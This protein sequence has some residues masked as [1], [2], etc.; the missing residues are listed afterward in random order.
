M[1]T[2]KNESYQSQFQCC[3]SEMKARLK[4]AMQN[5]FQSGQ[6]ITHIVEALIIIVTKSITRTY[7]V[8][9]CVLPKKVLKLKQAESEIIHSDQG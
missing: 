3:I 8:N 7:I 4:F 2:Q 9:T 5:H 6:L 1:L